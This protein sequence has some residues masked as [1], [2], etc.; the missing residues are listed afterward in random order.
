MAYVEAVKDGVFD[1]SFDLPIKI[2]MRDSVLKSPFESR[3]PLFITRDGISRMMESFHLGSDYWHLLLH[4]F[5]QPLS[6][7][8]TPAKFFCATPSCVPSSEAEFVASE[9]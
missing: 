5:P 3:P 2:L 6:T 8:N 1:C 9:E 4:G 7:I